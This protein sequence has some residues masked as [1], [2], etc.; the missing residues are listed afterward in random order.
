MPSAVLDEVGR[1]VD[2]QFLISSFTL[3]QPLIILSP[4]QRQLFAPLQECVVVF[5]D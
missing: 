5:S 4:F 3:A 1:R 2:T